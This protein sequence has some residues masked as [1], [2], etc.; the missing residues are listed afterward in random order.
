MRDWMSLKSLVQRI[1]AP[2]YLGLMAVYMSMPVGRAVWMR[3]PSVHWS[4][5]AAGVGL[6]IAGYFILVQQLRSGIRPSSNEN[7]FS[8]G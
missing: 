3:L 1:L 7:A 6:C 8:P 4:L 5:Q 2:A